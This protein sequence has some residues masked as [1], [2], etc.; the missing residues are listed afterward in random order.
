ML[1][2]PPSFAFLL[3]FLFPLTL[4]RLSSSTVR[5][6][7]PEATGRRPL[8]QLVLFLVFLAVIATVLTLHFLMRAPG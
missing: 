7:P 6:R 4:A 5:R 8:I 2:E 1:D 3:R